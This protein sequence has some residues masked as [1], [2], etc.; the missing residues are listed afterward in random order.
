M[1]CQHAS[2]G[3]H[4]GA[5]GERRARN[6]GNVAT[7]RE[8]G[9][10]PL[11]LEEAEPP[12]RSTVFRGLTEAHG[13]DT[14]DAVV[15]ADDDHE[16]LLHRSNAVRVEV[17]DPER[18]R[19]PTSYVIGHDGR[20]DLHVWPSEQPRPIE[21]GVSEIRRVPLRGRTRKGERQRL[22]LREELSRRRRRGHRADEGEHR[23]DGETPQKSHPSWTFTWFTPVSAAVEWS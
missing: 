8:C 5:G 18:P 9:P 22:V 21:L 6:V 2:G 4:D 15:G 23:P 19:A 11:R 20:L 13:L 16:H 14:A 12:Y 1:E 7:Q 10:Q 3:P 17:S